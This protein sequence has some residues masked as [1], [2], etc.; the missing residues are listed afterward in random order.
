M[1]GRLFSVC[2]KVFSAVTES[3]CIF[4]YKSRKVI[5]NVNIQIDVVVCFYFSRDSLVVTIDFILK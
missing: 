2:D 1:V 5:R 3:T 4:Y